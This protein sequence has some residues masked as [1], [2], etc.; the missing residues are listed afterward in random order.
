MGYTLG[1]LVRTGN[2]TL[3]HRW[4]PKKAPQSHLFIHFCEVGLVCLDSQRGSVMQV[5]QCPFTDE[6]ASGRGGPY[7]KPIVPRSPH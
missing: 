7:L 4:Q 1:S 3:I 5:S 6:K 2:Q